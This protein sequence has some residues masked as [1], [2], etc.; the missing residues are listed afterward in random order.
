[1]PSEDISYFRARAVE[2]REWALAAASP[3][4]RAVHLDFAG[5]Y[6]RMVARPR[7][8]EELQFSQEAIRRSLCLLRATNHFVNEDQLASLAR[9][10][11]ECL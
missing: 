9:L 3:A 11:S 5:R 4:V 6:D 10:E 1:M 7:S 8:A 2:E